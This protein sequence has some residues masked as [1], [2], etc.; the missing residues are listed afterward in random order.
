MTM[1]RWEPMREMV[2]LRNAMERLFDDSFVHPARWISLEGERTIPVD[3]YQTTN[4]VVVKASM[5]GF[6]PE[7]VDIEITGDVLTIKGELRQLQPGYR[8]SSGNQKRQS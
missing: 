8:Y 7:E 5:P 3:M 2:T 4:E 1:Q 6:K